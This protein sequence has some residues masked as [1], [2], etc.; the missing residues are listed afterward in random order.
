MSM[1]FGKLNFAVGFNRTSAFPLDANSYFENY[2]DAVAAAAGAAVVGS[3]DSAYYIGQ[4]IIVK[5]ENNFGLYQI[6]ATKTLVKFGQASSADDLKDQLDALA[7]RVDGLDTSKAGWGETSIGHSEELVVIDDTGQIRPSGHRVD[8]AVSDTDSNTNIPTSK[9]VRTYVAKQVASAVQYLGTVSALTGLSTTAG[10]GDFYRLSAAIEGAHAGDL[11]I[12][13]KDNPAQLID[14]INWTLVHGEEV[15]VESITAGTGIKIDTSG[16]NSEAQPKISIKPATKTAIG[17]IIVGTNLS[18]TADGE[19]SAINTTYEDVTTTTHGLMTAEDKIKLNGIEEGANKTIVDAS[20]DTTSTNPVE[21]KAVHAEF[22]QV[23]RELSDAESSLQGKI[24]QVS[25]NLSSAQTTLQANID[26]KVDKV[27]GKGLSTNDYT[28]AEKTKLEGLSNY[29]LPT[30]SADALGG[31]KIG[32]SGTTERTYAVQLDTN[33]K[34]YV[35]VPWTDD[36]NQK[37]TAKSG[38][39]NVTFGVND[40]VEIVAGTNVTV[41]PNTTDKTITIAST[42]TNTAHNHSA[43]VGLTGSGT[44]GTSGTYTYKVNLVNETPASN[45]ASYTSGAASKFYAVQLD[46]NSKL[47]VY[48]PWENNTFRPIKVNNGDVDAA[49]SIKFVNGTNISLALEHKTDGDNITINHAGPGSASQ[50]TT[51]TKGNPDLVEDGGTVN[52]GADFYVPSFGIDANGHTRELKMTK[53]SLPTPETYSLK[54]A[55]TTTLGGIKAGNGTENFS[56]GAEGTAKNYIAQ[57]EVD[58]N[59]LATVDLAKL[60]HDSDQAD[61]SLGWGIEAGYTYIDVVRLSTDKL[62]QGTNTLII[63]GGDAAW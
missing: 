60:V 21:N 52:F 40:T 3:S 48:V 45:A 24:D 27:E 34:A 20:L 1:D 38:G 50:T 4:L 31:I 12:A 25:A 10:K 15:G 6:S 11:V 62:V 57:V 55:T 63:N 42:D 54:P 29:T 37:I 49:A 7:E 44:A 13:E 2:T 43:G 58:N 59:G 22:T 51:G 9:A 36:T 47:G 41:T 56:S 14:G 30:A 8:Y 23:W 19:L 53:Y 39:S 28:D 35:N 26:D 18:I 16:T 46:K 61:H 5:D 33:S 32:Y 17:G